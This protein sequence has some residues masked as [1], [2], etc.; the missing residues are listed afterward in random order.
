[1]LSTAGT[2]GSYASGDAKVHG[3]DNH[4]IRWVSL[5]EENLPSLVED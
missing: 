4:G 1:M 3:T 5:K 2:A